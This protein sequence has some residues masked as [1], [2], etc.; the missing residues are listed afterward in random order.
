[1][2]PAS[3][4]FLAISSGSSS[5]KFVAYQVGKVPTPSVSGTLDRIGLGGTTLSWRP[6][7]GASRET[8]RRLPITRSP[9]LE[10]A[11]AAGRELVHVVLESQADGLRPA[12]ASTHGQGVA[13]QPQIE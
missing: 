11:C 10:D 9:D 1:M 6:T 2:A 7:E 3:G 12:V 5:T 4:S 8:N 13:C